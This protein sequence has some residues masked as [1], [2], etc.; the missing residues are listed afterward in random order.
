MS[1]LSVRIPKELEKKLDEEAK[2]AHKKRAELVR[3]ALSAYLRA[4]ER[5]RFLSRL[6]QA[7]R[8]MSQDEAARTEAS[9]V[10]EDFLP[11]DNEALDIAEGRRPGDPRPPDWQ[12]K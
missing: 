10:A 7:A 11:L 6:E 8:A 5:G 12:K 2:L 9:E 3:D 4:R 1:L